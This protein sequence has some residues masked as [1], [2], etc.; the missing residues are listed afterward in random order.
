MRRQSAYLQRDGQWDSTMTPMIDV[1]FLLLIFFV[2]T[3]SFHAIEYDLP[4]QVF[5][6]TS[7][8][9]AQQVDPPEVDFGKVEVE[10][11]YFEGRPLWTVNNQPTDRWSEVQRKMQAV[12]AVKTDVPVIIDPA[13]PVP[14]GVVI[15]MYDLALAVGFQDIK[16]VASPPLAA[17]P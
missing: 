8:G 14:L 10:I 16:F 5:A 15:D 4:S 2:W 11:E 13:N 12:A 3:A 9:A 7:A 17:A 6:T 1:V